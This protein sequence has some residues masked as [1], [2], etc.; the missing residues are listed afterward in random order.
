MFR[1]CFFRQI[2]LVPALAL[3][4]L[5]AGAAQAGNTLMRNPTLHGNSVVFEAHSNLWEVNRAVGT[6]RPVKPNA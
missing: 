4:A 2:V 6:A 3:L 1:S 5:V